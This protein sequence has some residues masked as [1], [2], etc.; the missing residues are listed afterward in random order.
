MKDAF[1]KVDNQS[2]FTFS[3]RTDPNQPVL[4]G[5]DHSIDLASHIKKQFVGCT[6]LSQEVITYV[7][8]ETAYTESQCKKALIYL[9]GNSEISVEVN[10]TDGSKRKKAT[11]PEGVVIHF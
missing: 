7:D 8:D 10:K 2:G 9:E 6:K 11:F 4:F 1:W 3:D 5:I